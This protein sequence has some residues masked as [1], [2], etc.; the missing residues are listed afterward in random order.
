MLRYAGHYFEIQAGMLRQFSF[1]PM[2][3]S[4]KATRIIIHP[5]YTPET[6]R[7]DVGMIKLDDPLRF[8]RWVRPV[9]LPDASLLGV[10]WRRQPEVNTTCIATGWGATKENGLDPDHLREVE[11][12]ILKSCKS[13]SDLNESMI[14]AGYPEGGRDTCQGDSGGPL[15]CK[16]PY[17]ESQ[18]YVAGIVSHGEGCGQADEPGV[19]TRVSYFLDWI[20]ENSNDQGLSPFPRSTLGKCPGFSCNGGLGRCLPIEL[21]CNGLVDCL[22][23]EDEQLCH[24]T[25]EYP[26]RGQLNDPEEKNQFDGQ[27]N[28]VPTTSEIDTISERTPTS[29][30]I[31][32]AE[33]TTVSSTI[34]SQV[35][36]ATTRVST[37][38]QTTAP[39]PS[40]STTEYFNRASTES[41]TISPVPPTIFTCSKLLQTIPIGKRCDRVV[42]CEDSTDEVNCTC[43]DFLANVKPSAICDGYVD[44]DDKSDE[45]NCE[46]CSQDEFYCRVTKDCISGA[47]KCDGHSDCPFMEDELD[48]FTLSNGHRVYLDADERPSLL[49]QGILTRNVNGKWRPVCHVPRMSQNQSTVMFIARNISQF[50]GFAYLESAEAV[51]VR[52]SELETVS[53]NKKNYASP[54][55][56]SAASL[57][58]DGK[59]CPGIKMRCRP[60]LNATESI[61]LIPD[62]GTGSR[63][64]LW[65]WI[66]AIFVDGSY[67]CSAILLDDSW[68]LSAS[69]CIENVR[70]D[71][72]YTTAVLGYG[73]LFRY[74]DGPHQQVTIIDELQHVN[75]SVSVLLH[76]KRPIKFNRYVQPLFVEKKIYLPGSNDACVAIGTNND[77]ETKSI[78]LRPVLKNCQNCQR[79]FVNSSIARCS[80]NETSEWSGTIFCQGKKGWYPAA[81]FEDDKGLCDFRDTQTFTSIDHINPYLTEALDKTRLSTEAPCDGFRC[82]FGQCISESRVCDGIP[83]CRDQADED[84]EYCGEI[85]RNCDNNI[86]GCHCLKSE[87]RCRNGKCVDKSAFCDGVVDCEDRSDEPDVCTC[88]EYLRLTEPGRL[89]D[90]VRHCL[91]KTDESPEICPCTD[92]SFQCMTSSGS[93]TCIPSDFVCDGES[94]CI[95]GEDE[96]ECRKLKTSP[97]NSSSIESGEIIHRS[98]GV[99]HTECFE[100]RVASHEEA[101]DICQS[102]GYTYGDIKNDTMATDKPMIPRGD[103]FYMVKLNDITWMTLRDDRPLVSLVEADENCHRAFVTCV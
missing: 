32:T 15:V 7:N 73:P 76:L 42:D 72:N 48:C 25:V 6:M 37:V 16:N 8:N 77:H 97:S 44:C 26:S 30:S 61:Y 69:K 9:C 21:R 41:S 36:D 45:Q 85:R 12:P 68:L 75:D 103:S 27:A 67:R 51:S 66:A 54:E 11:L 50:F 84:P 13:D 94:D 71:V 90:G 34:D 10:M 2:S 96:S 65:P 18:W 98:Y 100:D 92:S 95:N 99:W 4:R 52:D 62:A 82:N 40:T 83:D 74:V 39:E 80:E 56:Q 35:T 93:D 70:L 1:A 57:S 46:I 38:D 3:Q 86:D 81:A 88:A 79:C 63:G 59:T 78:S 20:R 47:K 23:G 29:E 28:A 55:W 22:D 49:M 89:C 53:W 58:D 91:D 101:N 19:Y 64:Y 102:L 87:L 60:V 5:Q 17:M 14:C 31:T 24:E 43:K 33:T